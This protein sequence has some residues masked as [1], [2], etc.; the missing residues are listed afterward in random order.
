MS[1]YWNIMYRTT[2]FQIHSHL[3]NFVLLL[4]N[5]KRNVKFHHRQHRVYQGGWLNL[6]KRIAQ[7]LY[8]NVSLL[9]TLIGSNSFWSYLVNTW[10]FLEVKT[11][12]PYSPAYPNHCCTRYKMRSEKISVN[13]C[14]WT[15]V[16]ISLVFFISLVWPYDLTVS[17][18]NPFGWKFLVTQY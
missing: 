18:H 16:S 2:L 5:K 7:W 10:N 14:H 3:F 8:L 15:L 6:G 13:G 9:A 11:K 1:V 4:N 12:P 17:Q